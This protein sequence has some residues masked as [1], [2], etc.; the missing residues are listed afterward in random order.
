MKRF[1]LVVALISC[2]PRNV[3]QGVPRP[4]PQD[5]VEWSSTMKATK[6]YVPA[7]ANGAERA[8]CTL[9]KQTDAGFVAT[10]NGSEVYCS[11]RGRVVTRGC[12]YTVSYP[13]C[14]G[15]WKSIISFIEIESAED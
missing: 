10:C 9:G 1:V 13:R 12:A 2:E 15:I 8:G 5:P 11:Q 4:P 7:I 6:K 14:S 3:R